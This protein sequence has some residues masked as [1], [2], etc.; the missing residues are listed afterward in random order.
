ML[1][2]LFTKF[3]AVLTDVLVEVGGLG[4]LVVVGLV[5]VIGL[6]V[7]VGVKYLT[8]LFG[9]LS[10]TVDLICLTVGL[11]VDCLEVELLY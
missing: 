10:T 2:E 7:E 8:A 3:F 11:P 5:A 6:G 4:V 9:I 1:L